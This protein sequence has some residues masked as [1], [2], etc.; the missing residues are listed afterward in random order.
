ML[1]DAHAHI[2]PT[3]NGRIGDGETRSI[4]YGKMRI[5]TD[6]E[7]RVLPPVAIETTF[8]PEVL[9]EYMNW[10]GID[11]TVLLQG[12]FYGECNRYA[13]EAIRRWPHRFFGTAFLDPWS[14]GARAMFDQAIDELGFRAVKLELSEAA[15]LC[16]I[17]PDLHLD[18][19][20]V[21]WLWDEMAQ[22][23]ML[24]TLDLG[25]IGS[26]PYQTD[27]VRRII[28]QHPHLRIVIAHLCQPN[29]AAEQDKAL[30]TQWQE[31]VQLACRPNVW[32]DTAALPA[33]LQDEGYPFPSVRRYLKMAVEIT[34]PDKIL[35]GTDVPGLLTVATYRQLVRLASEHTDFLSS[36]DRAKIMG[37][38]AL[39]VYG[40]Q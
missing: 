7:E 12:T 25:A 40:P 33:Y 21:S 4:G 15:G 27:A 23:N 14:D 20:Q 28:E 32:L 6:Q 29:L 37:L 17:H 31:Q 18:D 39:R 34:G 35:W 36:E 5:G 24:L 11:R 1:I 13:A 8:P 10:A 30:W 9:I 2:F 3:V 22:R 26:R 16:G 38:N 19:P